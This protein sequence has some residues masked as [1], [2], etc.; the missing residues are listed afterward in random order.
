MAGADGHF[1]TVYTLKSNFNVALLSAHYTLEP[2][3]YTENVYPAKNEKLLIV[4]IAAKN[5][6]SKDNNFYTNNTFMTAIDA[7]GVETKNKVVSLAS[8]AE[9]T[10]DPTIKPGQGLGQPGL[11][12]PL[13]VVFIVPATSR[14]VKLIL[15]FG[16]KGRAEEVVRYYIAGATKEEAGEPGDPANIV[17]PLPAAVRDPADPT[18]DTPLALGK[19]PASG[20]VIS[21][22]FALHLD[23]FTYTR[24]PAV[25]DDGRAPNEDEQFA[26][27]TI[28]A[29]T[30]IVG[31][32]TPD[33][34]LT[35]EVIVKDADGETVKPRYR[36]KAHGSAAMDFGHV[37]PKGESYTFRLVF[38]VHKATPQRTLILGI[39]QGRLW[40]YDISS[41]K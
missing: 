35:D 23:S 21:G 27:A 28:T 30:L 17:A 38:P 13:R 8:R 16:R 14:I 5:V 6:D 11:H 41:A 3:N 32:R 31:K 19:A 12:D 1:G 20:T 36:M 4:D 29:T 40:E 9:E 7:Q 26:V 37:I 22:P 2:F 24:D 34:I 25:G 33:P 10:N 39:N 18:G 15:N